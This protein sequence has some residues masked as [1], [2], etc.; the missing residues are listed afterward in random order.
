LLVANGA[1]RAGAGLVTLCGETELATALEHRVLEAMTARIDPARAADSALELCSDAGAVAIG[2]GVGLDAASREL[3]HAVVLGFSGRM[4]VDADALTHF[5]GRIEA[6]RG[7]AGQ[8]VLTPH[9]GEAARLLD[10]SVADVE[11]D[12]YAAAR[13][14]AERTGATVLLKGAY[15]LIAAPDHTT[16]VNTTGS[17]VLA[18]GGTGDVLCGIV[19]ALLCHA[20]PFDAAV[21]AA[22]VHGLASEAWTNRHRTDRGL[23]AHEIADDLPAAFASLA[24]PNDVM[25]V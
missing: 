22:F 25:P 6:L 11:S 17:P 7:A 5:A 23:L 9:P 2:P 16:A 19:A 10:A 1:L 12:R 8:L 21:A 4:V 18:T 14:L 3:V 24:A 15:T 13:T 20:P